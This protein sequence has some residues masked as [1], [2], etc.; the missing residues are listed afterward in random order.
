MDSFCSVTKAE[1]MRKSQLL[2]NKVLIVT[3]KT[4]VARYELRMARYNHT[5]KIYYNNI[6][7]V[8]YKC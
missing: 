5:A 8:R 4:T 1:F 7:I 6:D 2:E 3:C